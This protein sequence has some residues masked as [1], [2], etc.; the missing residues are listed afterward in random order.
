MSF[1]TDDYFKLDISLPSTNENSDIDDAIALYEPEILKKVL[2]FELYDLIEDDES[3]SG[4]LYELINGKQYTV[5]WD[6]RD[7]KVKWNGLQNTEEINLM[8]Y[9]I[10]FMWQTYH[11]SN[12][13]NVGVVAGEVEL[14]NRVSPAQKMGSAYHKLREL[15][16]YVGQQ[17]LEPSLYNFLKEHES[18]YPEWVFTDV[19]RVNRFGI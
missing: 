17:I 7:Q 11:A 5:S 8:A 4:R 9:Y 10:Y 16:G 3:T 15:A 19:G 1:T 18:D 12:T 14:S 6:G 13:T 2:G